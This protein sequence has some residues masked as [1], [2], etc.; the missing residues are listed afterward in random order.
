MIRANPILGKPAN[1]I[2]GRGTFSWNL[3]GYT[4]TLYRDGRSYFVGENHLIALDADGR[5]VKGALA[6]AA[7]ILQ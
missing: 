2:E 6:E 3:A 5:R 1:R 4:V 7:D